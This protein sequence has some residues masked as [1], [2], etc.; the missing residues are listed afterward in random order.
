MLILRGVYFRVHH[1][2][3]GCEGD[4]LL[5]I[6]HTHTHVELAREECGD[7]AVHLLTRSASDGLLQFK[8]VKCHT[9]ICAALFVS[10]HET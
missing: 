8:V 3:N 2:W 5:G 6:T 4:V 10:R 9:H 1:P 7:Q